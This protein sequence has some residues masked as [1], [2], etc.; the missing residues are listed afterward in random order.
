MRLLKHGMTCCHTC[1]YASFCLWLYYRC[2]GVA[3]TQVG[4]SCRTCTA[5]YS[6]YFTSKRGFWL[7]V[8]LMQTCLYAPVRSYEAFRALRESDAWDH[9]PEARRR[10]VEAEL[11]DFVLG[12]VALEVCRISWL[13][14]TQWRVRL[15][16]LS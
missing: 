14:A 12:G 2:G 11:R 15:R 5:S 13:I 16:M 3:S 9:M 8:E 10:A 1:P 7:H 4:P 6:F